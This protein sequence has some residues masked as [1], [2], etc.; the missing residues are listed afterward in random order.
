MTSNGLFLTGTSVPVA[1][2]LKGV[3]AD[4]VSTLIGSAVEVFETMVGIPLA[5]GVPAVGAPRPS[6]NVVGTVGFGGSSSGLVSFGCSKA[7]ALEITRAL[8]GSD[9]DSA[10]ADLADSIGEITNMVAGSFRTKMATSEDR[11]A[12]SVPTVTVGDDFLIKCGSNTCYVICPLA[13]G[14][15][16][17]FV[18]LVLQH[19]D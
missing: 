5:V 11:W 8:L 6:T 14:E 12:I 4:M 9:E 17:M 16:E 13:M 19:A 3:H 15:H 18:E 1:P 2:E 10:V 7:A